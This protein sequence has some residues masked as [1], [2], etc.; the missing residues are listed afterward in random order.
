EPPAVR[1]VSMVFQEN[2]L[3]AHLS[4][5]QN[6]GLGR[7]PS[8][9]LTDTDHADIAGALARTGLA[10]KEKRLPR[11]LSGGERQRVA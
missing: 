1:P 2:N 3:F 11:E 8:L 9:R 4:V 7:S 10:G 6:V 5:E